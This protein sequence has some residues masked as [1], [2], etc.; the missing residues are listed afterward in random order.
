MRKIDSRTAT[1]KSGQIQVELKVT[2]QP[3]SLSQDQSP[4]DHDAVTEIAQAES[5]FQN[6]KIN[7]YLSKVPLSGKGLS[8]L[9]NKLKIP[10]T[11]PN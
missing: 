8:N 3:K 9:S 5:A 11:Q 2:E 4:D 6:G 1:L 7:L 10:V